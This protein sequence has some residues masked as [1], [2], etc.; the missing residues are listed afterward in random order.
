MRDSP[1]DNA[2]PPVPSQPIQSTYRGYE[3]ARE[4]SLYAADAS[5]AA[6]ER[7]KNNNFTTAYEVFNPD[8]T[9]SVTTEPPPVANPP[10]QTYNPSNQ[11]GFGMRSGNTGYQPLDDPYNNELSSTS[12]VPHNE[13]EMTS[14]PMGSYNYNNSD[15]N[16]GEVANFNNLNTR[17]NNP[18]NHNPSSF[19]DRYYNLDD[20]AS[21]LNNPPPPYASYRP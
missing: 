1:Y 18:P 8:G 14:Y 21:T 7:P 5:A 17:S 10:S 12:Y 16:N 13:I 20:S 2:G 4:P 15:N 11:T 19:A 9:I 3:P 6:S